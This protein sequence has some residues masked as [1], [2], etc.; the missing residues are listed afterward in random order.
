MNFQ[1]KHRGVEVPESLKIAIAAKVGRFET[2]VPE[3]A[4]IEVELTHHS[5]HHE[6]KQEAEVMLDIPGSKQV[7]RFKAT[8]ETFLSA[9]D[10]VL[11]KLDDEMSRVRDKQ[12]D[13]SYKGKSPKEW[14]ADHANTEEQ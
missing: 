1:L 9:V 11:D 8:A 13:H 5:S 7:V 10:I 4:Y 2:V 14:L 12:T 6:G 3:N